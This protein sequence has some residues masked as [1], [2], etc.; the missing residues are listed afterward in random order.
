MTDIALSTGLLE[1]Q[2]GKKLPF[3]IFSLVHNV[4]ALTALKTTIE[5]HNPSFFIRGTKIIT[6]I[7]KIMKKKH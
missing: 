4:K 1:L 5:A 2:S 3:I 7:K 6:Q